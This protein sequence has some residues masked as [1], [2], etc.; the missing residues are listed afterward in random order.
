VAAGVLVLFFLLGR[1]SY[2]SKFTTVLNTI[3]D[4]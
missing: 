1:K 2:E 3:N 4:S